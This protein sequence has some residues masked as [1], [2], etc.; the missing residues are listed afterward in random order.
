LFP[1]VGRKIVG[2]ILISEI[3][4]EPGGGGAT[5]ACGVLYSKFFLLKVGGFFKA[6]SP[7]IVMPLK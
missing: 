2:V 7:M 5:L 4:L 6:A 3:L 1:N